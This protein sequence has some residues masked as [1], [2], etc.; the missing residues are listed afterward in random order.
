MPLVTCLKCN[1]TGKFWDIQCDN[2]YGMGSVTEHDSGGSGGGGVRHRADAGTIAFLAA[3]PAAI[4][5]FFYAASFAES[6][7]PRAIVAVVV[8]VV[9]YYTL[10]KPLRPL[11]SA[12][13][14]IINTIWVVVQWLV[15]IALLGAMA[16]GA[17]WLASAF[18]REYMT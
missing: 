1:G 8:F 11:S 7:A 14:A 6:F 15:K 9:I 5:S 13:A 4:V 17:L 3:A 16:A 10:T 2:C 12:I 18:F